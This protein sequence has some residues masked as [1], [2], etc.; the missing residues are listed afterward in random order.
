VRLEGKHILPPVGL[1][2]LRT[3]DPRR[4]VY[5]F[6]LALIRRSGEQGVVRKPSQTPS[7]YAVQ[8]EKA[9]PLESE[10]IDSI[11][12]AFVE[13]RYSRQEVD[14]RKAELVKATWGRIRRALQEKLKREKSGNK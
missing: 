12:A 13:A 8:L 9:L 2:S 10:D 3:L 7:E 11:T 5:F 1:I 14:S 6:Y 4:R